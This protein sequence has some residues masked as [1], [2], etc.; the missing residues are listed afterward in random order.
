MTTSAARPVLVAG[1][2]NTDLVA[3][4]AKAPAAGETVT[5]SAFA[6]FGGGKGANQAIA[7]ARSGA[8]TA[9]LGALGNDDFGRARRADLDAEGIDT[10]SVA[11]HESEP[12]GVA[13]IVVEEGS[14]QNRISYVPGATLTIRPAQA[15]H[16]VKRI[17]PAV[18]LTT[19][20]PVPETIAA[21]IESTHAAGGIVVLNASPEPLGA[22]P[23]LPDL[24][25]LI[26]NETEAEELLGRE[27]TLENGDEAALA[28]AALGPKTVVITLGPAGA[29]VAHEG[30][31]RYFPA[32]QVTAVDTT[33]AGDSFTG[34]FAADLASGGDPFSAARRG[35]VA[36]SLATTKPGAYPSIP[37]RADIEAMLAQLA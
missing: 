28:L 3:R 8:P 25:I 24:D 9:M 20:E 19:L 2:I 35:V 5:G 1:A 32:P 7:T 17:Q 23:F 15:R 36:G 27:V 14:G 29:V 26:V 30:E 16:A 4:V 10:G 11:R 33:A 22:R 37:H 31:T 13:L 21:L 12:S 6:I 18:L 34:A